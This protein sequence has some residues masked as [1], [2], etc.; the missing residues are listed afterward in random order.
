MP[1]KIHHYLFL[2]LLVSCTSRSSTTEN[3]L[4]D[5]LA[6]E[7]DTATVAETS[8][9]EEVSEPVSYEESGENEQGDDATAVDSAWFSAFAQDPLLISTYE[10]MKGH[11][12]QSNIAY[13]DT[14]K[15]GDNA[16][17]FGN[18]YITANVTEAYG[19]LLCSAYIDNADFPL[20]KGLTIGMSKQE[21]METTGLP[22]DL[23]TPDGARESFEYTHDEQ[24]YWWMVTFYF[25]ENTLTAMKFN[26]SSCIIYD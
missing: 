25:E 7:I 10:D 11:L 22:S 13:K 23:I 24:D 5:S 4:L 20:S 16:L 3:E 12:A 18:S 17:I 6:A 9:V 2:L 15:D 26:L 8:V 19:E 21:F 14:I 1:M